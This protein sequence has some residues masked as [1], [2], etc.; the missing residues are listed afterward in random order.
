MELLLLFSLLLLLGYPIIVAKIVGRG[1]RVK[2]EDAA[3]RVWE[4][5]RL[6]VQIQQ[7]LAK[8]EENRGTV[9]E[10]P[11]A[12]TAQGV[13]SAAQAL[14]QPADPGLADAPTPAS[15]SE[16]MVPVAAALPAVT[17]QIAAAQTTAAPADNEAAPRAAAGRNAAPARPG[18]AVP[19][20]ATPT[21]RHPA[22]AW[23]LT[24]NLVT[25]FG[26]LILIIGVGFLL[27]YTAQ[28]V[29]IPI[30]L[31]L[32][33]VVVFALALLRW[34][35]KI[36]LPR[37]D[38]SLSVQ[39]A[40]T[41]ILM[42]V[43]YAA[44]ARF[45]LIPAALAFPLLVVL[46]A[47]T[48]LLAAAQDALWLAVFGIAAGFAAPILV[49]T[50]SGN[51][52]A[53][54]SYYALL[55]AGIL[56][57]ALRR[58]WRVLNLIGFWSTFLIGGAWGVTRYVDENYVSAQPFVILFF[59]FYV[60]IA[61]AWAGHSS[62][63]LKDPI[64]A[65]LVFGT[66]AA[67]IALQY[68]MV[69]G[70][71]F[72]MA[73]SALAMA[74]FYAV[75]AAALLRRRQRSAAGQAGL[76]DAFTA[77]ATVFA[78]LTIPFAANDAWTSAAWAFEGVGLI[79]AGLRQNRKR[80]WAFGLLVQYGAWFYYLNDVNDFTANPIRQLDIL[81]LVVASAW[82][83]T[84]VGQLSA[85]QCRACS[86]QFLAAAALLVPIPGWTVL[87]MY[88]PADAPLL[89]APILLA[90][91]AGAASWLF[92]QDQRP[93][94]SNGML[95]WAGVWWF[96]PALT[97]G[98]GIIRGT[99]AFARQP[100]ETFWGGETDFLADPGSIQ[101]S[102][103][104]ALV[105]VCAL[106]ALPA[107]RRLAW[108]T[109]RW[110]SVPAWV[111]LS[112][113][114]AAMLFVLNLSRAGA[115]WQQTLGWAVTWLCGDLLLRRWD[116]AGWPMQNAWRK[117][118]HLVRVG[119][120]WLMLWPYLSRLVTDWL[121]IDP[122]QQALLNLSGWRVSGS[123]AHFIP[124]WA[125]I[126]LAFWLAGRSRAGGWPTAPLARWY[127]KVVVP[128]ITGALLLLVAYWNLQQDG[129]MA[130]LPFMP[131]LNPL[132]ITTLCALLL[133]IASLHLWRQ[134]ANGA[135]APAARMPRLIAL[136][137]WAWLNAC[138]LRTA[139]HLAGIP[140]ELQ[141]LAASTLIQAML[142]IVWSVSAL[143]IMRYAGTAAPRRRGTGKQLWL[144]GAVLL[145]VVVLK[146]FIFDLD[147]K[148]TVERIVSFVGVGLMMVLIGY[149]AP[150]VPTGAQEPATTPGPRG[151]P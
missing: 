99:Y 109:L 23:L 140:Y 43:V 57:L 84:S 28:H 12:P 127:R 150:Y 79:W 136:A 58:R 139:A 34:G 39:G 32:A 26:L 65:T 86:L 88:G 11:V 40:A 14:R 7:R 68:G 51:H 35:W 112:V 6:I 55:D 38:L 62:T 46:T 41:G 16:P 66:P 114:T 77:I 120:P 70:T 111:A 108:P 142:S 93:V 17:D 72:G 145:G 74:A 9:Q 96:W 36:R 31:R 113:S 73:F 29:F 15:A 80:T 146:L 141:A 53:L 137:A 143:A 115:T 83:G 8:L 97:I 87:R 151:E 63:R 75:L 106:A 37:R 44:F 128:V 78:T 104:F 13:D 144:F 18:A 123:W 98:A 122:S 134:D 3:A 147:N 124:A 100:Q 148:G 24:G 126:G 118:L 22:I 101:T 1:A 130:P 33:G 27:T 95:I 149:V 42:L 52:V 49:A 10:R 61:L 71:P 56:W 50:G 107:T 2:L 131:L 129:S 45:G 19:E 25:K 117:Y 82:S 133:A 102:I 103:Y 67:V 60:G 64:D 94:A 5:D 132:D 21:P 30:E 54:F 138:L 69:G 59:L 48:C 81:L 125:M 90:A 76:I 121:E 89:I 110:F 47:C 119:G 105:S 116:K 85:R 135:T 92:R 4:Q 91:C 20:R